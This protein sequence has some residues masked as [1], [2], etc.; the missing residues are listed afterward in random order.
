MASYWEGLHSWA[1]MSPGARE[2]GEIFGGDMTAAG[3]VGLVGFH[4]MTQRLGSPFQKD[5]SAYLLAL[6]AVPRVVM[7]DFMSWAQ[8]IRH[9]ELYGTFSAGFG[10]CWVTSLKLLSNDCHDMSAKDP[11][12]GTGPIGPIGAQ[13]ELLDLPVTRC[14]RE[15]IAWEKAFQK[16]CPDDG[17]LRQR[18][19]N[20]L[21]HIMF[22]T[23]LSDQFRT[24]AT[25]F[26]KK[27]NHP[28]F[29]LRHAHVL[30]GLLAWDVP[31]RLL[32]WSPGLIESGTWDDK[33]QT[34][35]MQIRTDEPAT[36]RLAVHDRAFTVK[37][38]GKV[39]TGKFIDQRPRWRVVSIQVPPGRH[40]VEVKT[41][42]L[43]ENDVRD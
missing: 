16:Q 41:S 24:Q 42:G 4:E 25:A 34:A 22:R 35:S 7:F 33:T 2:A 23:Y 3:Y 27:Y 15:A 21:S 29:Q 20:V 14:R 28:K 30:A 31:V 39:V 6:N 17:F 10:E 37:V 1:L 12:W 11:W 32:D 13:P 36:V 19:D 38:D 18:P 26:M 40:C 5:L 9:P 43:S 8:K